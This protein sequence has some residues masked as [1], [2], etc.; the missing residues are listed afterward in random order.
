[1][2]VLILKELRKKND[3][4]ID[5]DDENFNILPIINAEDYD[6]FKKKLNEVEGLKKK[7]VS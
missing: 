7:L 3:R 2:Q 4:D 6:T 5:E 1:M